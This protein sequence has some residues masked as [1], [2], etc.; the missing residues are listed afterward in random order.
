MSEFKPPYLLNSV[1]Y[2]VQIF[3]M[4]RTHNVLLNDIRMK[5]EIIHVL[6]IAIPDKTYL[7]CIK[8]MHIGHSLTLCIIRTAVISI[9]LIVRL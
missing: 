4:F 6:K 9:F 3:R 7:H 5:V 8:G 2:F 1:R